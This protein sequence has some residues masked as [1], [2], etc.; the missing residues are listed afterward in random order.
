MMLT[1]LRLTMA[2]KF[3]LSKKGLLLVAI[4]L[5]FE[6][7]FVLV[8]S[9]LLYTSDREAARQARAK[10]IAATSNNISRLFFDGISTL[11]LYT[12][13]K[14]DLIG[15]RCEQIV[16]KIRSQ[17]QELKT[18]GSRYPALNER[19]VAVDKAAGKSIDLLI[20]AKES[21]DEGGTK[22]GTM[23]GLEK[24]QRVQECTEETV[25][26]LSEYTEEA[27]RLGKYDPKR[28]LQI[29][30][31]I[32]KLLLLAIVLSIATAIY[33]ALFFSR[34]ISRRVQTIRDNAKNLSRGENLLPP[35]G[36]GDEIKELDE[37]FRS[38]AASL[39]EAEQ[40]KQEFVS[41]LSHDL[42]SPLSALRIFLSNFEQ[43]LA[44]KQLDP[45]ICKR[46]KASQQSLNRLIGLINDLLDLDKISDGKMELK[47]T[48]FFLNDALVEA[49]DMVAALSDAK[50][51][52]I[53]ISETDIEITA[54]EEKI[55]RLLINLLSNAI[56][57]S[58]EGRKICLQIEETDKSVE[59]HVID[60]GP[61]ISEEE[62]EKVF[63]RF[64]QVDKS[65]AASGSGLGLSICR[66][67]VLSHGGTIG[68]KSM[69]GAGSD[70][71]FK[72]PIA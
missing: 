27:V 4:P 55:S 35:V 72:L 1:Q 29:R 44:D 36:G 48:R 43:D 34:D 7:A 64:Y 51:L 66:A 68:V 12:F 37:V 57:F 6:L 19:F 70:F 47:P 31:L 63:Q 39:K 62:Q 14:D 52:Q 65:N 53:E 21:I 24:R 60:E 40:R 61:G 30:N 71:W 50:Q 13:S 54:D 17:L 9:F 46:L 11:F 3:N 10:E 42:R 38:M 45:A 5:A 20:E 18:L 25:R 16:K 15:N 33:I 23:R 28:I 67:I 32:S 58:P 22:L 41:M 2:I 69:P 59:L 49:L 56:K 8:L 26:Q